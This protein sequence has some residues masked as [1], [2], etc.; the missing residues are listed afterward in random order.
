VA[1]IYIKESIDEEVLRWRWWAYQEPYAS[2][3]SYY[4]GKV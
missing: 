1:Y 4:A 3:F 2:E